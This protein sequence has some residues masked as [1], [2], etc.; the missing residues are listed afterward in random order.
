MKDVAKTSPYGAI[1]FVAAHFY[2]SKV[3][4]TYMRVKV[5]T[6]VVEQSVGTTDEEEQNAMTTDE[7]EQNPTKVMDK[8]DQITNNTEPRENIVERPASC[9]PY[10]IYDTRFVS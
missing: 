10:E 7:A 2:G 8:V 3:P 1:R 5:V 6:D 4:V 9:L